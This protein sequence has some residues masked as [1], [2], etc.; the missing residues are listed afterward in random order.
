MVLSSY[1]S[2]NLGYLGIA[3]DLETARGLHPRDAVELVGGLT[4]CFSC[5]SAICSTC[6]TIFRHNGPASGFRARLV[7]KS[8]QLSGFSTTLNSDNTSCGSKDTIQLRLFSF[9][10]LALPARD[11]TILQS[12]ISHSFQ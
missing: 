10:T 12:S 4:A 3:F 1:P 5:E 2:G 6:K 7:C 11:T 9:P 8:H